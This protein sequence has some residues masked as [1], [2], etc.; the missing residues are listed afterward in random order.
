MHVVS[1]A[2]VV[3][4][5]V[6]MLAGADVARADVG[7]PTSYFLLGGGVDAFT[8]STAKNLWD[9]GGTWDLRL[10]GGNRSYLGTELA[11]VGALHPAKSGNLDLLANGAE[12]VVRLQAPYAAGSGWLVEPFAFGGIGWSYLSVR[13]APSGVKDT[14]NIGQ[15]PFGAGVTFGMNRF[16]VDARFTYRWTFNEDLGGPGGTIRLHNWAVNAAIGYEF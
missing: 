8:D 10:G 7:G 5:A 12:A 2:A 13:N 14:D 3:A 6:M 11:Y 9:T 1:R 15:V 4:A 16:L